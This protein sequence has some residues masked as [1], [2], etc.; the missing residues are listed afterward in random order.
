MALPLP[1]SWFVRAV[2]VVAFVFQFRGTEVRYPF[3]PKY[4]P[5]TPLRPNPRNTELSSLVASSFPPPPSLFYLFYFIL[6]LYL[7]WVI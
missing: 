4:V 1:S 6:F 5:T 7:F 3:V 2:L